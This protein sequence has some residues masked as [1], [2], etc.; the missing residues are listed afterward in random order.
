MGGDEARRQAKRFRGLDGALREF[1]GDLYKGVFLESAAEVLDI[2]ITD[3]QVDL[4]LNRS[5]ALLESLLAEFERELEQSLP[6]TAVGLAGHEPSSGAGGS[7][8]DGAAKSSPL[9]EDFI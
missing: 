5:D 3:K 7:P 9:E 2:D 4:I 1:C 8:A 6:G